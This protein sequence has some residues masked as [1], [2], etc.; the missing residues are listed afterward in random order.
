MIG[1]IYIIE[2]L[3]TNKKYV[4]LTTNIK[5]REHDHFSYLRRNAHVNQKLQNA[6]NKYG[7]KDFTFFYKEF[8]IKDFEQ[9][10]ELEIEYIEKYNS[11]YEGYNLTLGGDGQMPNKQKFTFE[12]YCMIR[13]GCSTYKGLTNIVANYYN[14]ANSL[15]CTIKNGEHYHDCDTRFKELN[16]IEKREYL[17]D[18]EELFSINKNNLP[19]KVKRIATTPQ[20]RVQI[21][22][23]CEIYPYGS[24]GLVQKFFEIEKSA[25]CKMKKGNTFKEE[26]KIYKDLSYQEKLELSE[27]LKKR[28]GVY[29]NVDNLVSLSDYFLMYKAYENGKSL[30]DISRHLN[31]NVATVRHAVK[32]EHH[33]DLYEKYNKLTEEEKTL[34]IPELWP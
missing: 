7:E 1:Y 24:S 26:Y 20:E 32:Q 28:I 31:I 5:K 27:K 21:L 10:K 29:F 34:L 14:C 4:G 33:K 8:E 25:F 23:F 9:L 2:N 6:F 11:Y 19:S 12:E 13:M 15:I 3:T 22:C 30:A 17:K 16:E 18:F